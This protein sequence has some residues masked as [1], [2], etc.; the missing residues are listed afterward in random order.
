MKKEMLTSASNISLFS[1]SFLS[2]TNDSKANKQ[3]A[4]S[5]IGENI[6]MS[7][8][9]KELRCTSK[10]TRQSVLELVVMLRTIQLINVR[11]SVENRSPLFK[12]DTEMEKA[13]D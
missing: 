5:R 1:L 6:S 3:I 10:K 13:A 12:I 2:T 4:V 11:I 7:K 8:N 9:I